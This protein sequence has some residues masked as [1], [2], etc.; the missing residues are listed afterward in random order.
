[1]GAVL[2]GQAVF[3]SASAIGVDADA[4]RG[5]G[6][7]RADLVRAALAPHGVT[8]VTGAA[9]SAATAVLAS[10]WFPVGYAA[11]LD[12]DRG[13]RVLPWLVIA[14]VASL[15]AVLAMT[16]FLGAATATT[17]T[18]RRR[19]TSRAGGAGPRR[20][21]PLS[22]ALGAAMAFEGR[23]GRRGTG[24]RAALV[25]AAAAV[26]G[27]VG[28][29]T[30]NGGLDDALSHPARAGVTW[31]ATVG[32][33][34][35]DLTPDGVR[36][37]LIDEVRRQA[38]VVAAAS[39]MRS[40]A[41]LSGVGT[42]VY[43]LGDAGSAAPINFAL[44][45][46]RLPLGPDEVAIGP[47]TARA[48]GTA[49][50]QRVELEGGIPLKVVG[51]ALFPNDVHTQFDEGAVIVP[52]EF[53]RFVAVTDRANRG[54]VEGAV[55]VRL[56]TGRRPGPIAALDQAFAG[57]TQGVEPAPIPLELTN[58][59]NVR[60]LPLL[61]AGFLL[62]LGLS[63]IGH[64]L[65]TSVRRRARELAITRALGMTR[66]NT[67]AMI[68]AQATAIAVFGLVAG[69]PIGIASGRSGWR[70]ITRRV[71]LAFVAPLALVAIVLIA[72]AA[73][74]LA[75]ALAV[76]PSRRAGRLEP[77]RILRSE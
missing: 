14:G 15:A 54:N 33:N 21:R 35:S 26:A 8:L 64:G 1:V 65:F 52:D 51:I 23:V 30:L 44:V 53:A 76:I 75:N 42:Q 10:R 4:L 71:P 16:A 63:A 43:A 70:E 38:G 77:A 41:S 55:A 59:R 13:V 74:A 19:T 31:D 36:P 24:A 6:M 9:I 49:I 11:T 60:R 73:V 20:L 3:R 29:V 47:E 39:V 69:V 62:A 45:R 56:A 66:R 5:M 48:T 2:V 68:A 18:A 34:P 32:A 72:P 37:T 28:V 58:L 12:P 57:R 7:T 61:L 40:V 17:P 27:I 25:G 50:G 67:W 46:G 22:L